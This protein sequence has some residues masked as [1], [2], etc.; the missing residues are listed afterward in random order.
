[1][2]SSNQNMNK[3]RGSEVDFYYWTTGQ[4]R[5]SLPAISGRTVLPTRSPWQVVHKATF[6]DYQIIGNSIENSLRAQDDWHFDEI[7]QG[8]FRFKCQNAG[9]GLVVAL[10]SSTMDDMNGYYIVLDDDN[11]E[12]YVMQLHSLGANRLNQNTVGGKLLGRNRSYRRVAGVTVD[13]NFRLNPDQQYQF[14]VMYQQ[15]SLI[16]GQGETPGL[17]IIVHMDKQSNIPRSMG[18]DVNHYGFARLGSRWPHA[19]R[20]YDVETLNY[21]QGKVIPFPTNPLVTTANPASVKQGSLLYQGSRLSQ[22]AEVG[23]RSDKGSS[24]PASFQLES[25]VPSLLRRPVTKYMNE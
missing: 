4:R 2:K 10:T 23:G 13:Q 1:M 7:G 15:G 24:V 11:H 16:M 17:N 12:S 25:K 20:V 9:S 14:Y 22:A 18:R 3:D 19:L 21:T 5:T 8:V 6:N